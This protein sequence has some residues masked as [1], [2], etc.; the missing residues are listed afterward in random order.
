VGDG[1]T[2]NAP[3][4][5]QCSHMLFHFTSMACAAASER[6]R[7]GAC[8]SSDNRSALQLLKTD[9]DCIAMS[10]QMD[11]RFFG[12]CPPA[13]K[14]ARFQVRRLAADCLAMLSITPK[15]SSRLARKSGGARKIRI[16]PRRRAAAGAVFGYSTVPSQV[17]HRLP[18]TPGRLLSRCRP[19]RRNLNSRW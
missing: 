17:F 4:N 2:R 19:Q 5:D 6:V 3:S 16:S 1:R 7:V 10:T 12:E 11:Q 15:V 14:L 8:L 13:D 18:D 9:L